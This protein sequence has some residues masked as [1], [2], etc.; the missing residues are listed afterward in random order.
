[1]FSAM[2][3]INDFINKKTFNF[4]VHNNEEWKKGICRLVQFC[5]LPAP[6]P[7]LVNQSKLH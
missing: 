6:Y 3:R 4:K 1:M 2:M 5:P 7:L